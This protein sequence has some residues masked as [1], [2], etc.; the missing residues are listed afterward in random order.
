M[1][2]ALVRMVEARAAA[3]GDA[4][5]EAGIEGEDVV[6]AGRGLRARWLRDLVMREAGRGR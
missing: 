6:A 4:G 3:L 5:V 2:A 1:R